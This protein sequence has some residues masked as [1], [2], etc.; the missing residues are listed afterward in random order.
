VIGFTAQLGLITRGETF[1][2]ALP[3]RRI[4][5][6]VEEGETRFILLVR[7]VDFETD[8]DVFVEF[9]DLIALGIKEGD[10][11]DGRDDIRAVDSVGNVCG[12]DRHCSWASDDG[13]WHED[14]SNVLA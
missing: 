4:F 9:C 1:I 3:F 5:C 2:D 12:F 10:V 6:L 13:V 8:F 7:I 11:D 14:G